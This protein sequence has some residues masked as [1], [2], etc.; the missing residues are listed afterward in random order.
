MTTSSPTN[1][2]NQ[3]YQLAIDTCQAIERGGNNT[4]ELF[5]I[6]DIDIT[7]DTVPSTSTT[8]HRQDD[9]SNNKCKEILSIFY[10]LIGYHTSDNCNSSS[11]AAAVDDNMDIPLSIKAH[12]LLKALLCIPHD[13]YAIPW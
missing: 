10:T 4:S 12:L 1:N 7:N 2:N 5:S 9:V 11:T 8:A 6:L 13:R 3:R